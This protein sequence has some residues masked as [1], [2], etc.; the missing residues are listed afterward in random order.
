[1]THKTLT[2][3]DQ[4]LHGADYNPEQW[5]SHPEILAE[6]IRLMKLAGCN[7][8]SVGIFSWASLEPEE[9]N[10]TFEW[11]DHV[12]ENLYAN[13]IS[14]ILAT[15]SGARPA[16]LAQKYPEVLRT[17]GEN[18]KMKYGGRHN[19]CWSSRIYREK[20][21]AINSEL[22]LRYKDHPAI[23]MWHVSNEYGGE[24]FCEGCQAGFKTFIKDKYQTLEKLNEQYWTQFWSHAYTDW[25]QIEPPSKIGET[26]VHGLSID[27]RR[28]VTHQT[29]DF[30]KNEIEPLRHHTPHIPITTNFMDFYE[31]LDYH[32]F[33]EFLDVAS[34]DIYPPYRNNSSDL[35]VTIQ[36]AFT[37]DL[38]RG[39]KRKPFVLME[40]TPSTQNW[41]DI[42]TLKRPG[43]H[44][45]ASLQAVAHGADTVQYFQWRKSRG[46]SE[47]FH[48]AVVDHV[49]HEDTRVFKEVSEVGDILK[50]IKPV[51]A[52]HTTSKIA[53]VFDWDNWWAIN[54]YQGYSN[55]SKN[56]KKTCFSHYKALYNLG[57]NVDVISTNTSLDGY[58]MV[59]APQ[60]YMTKEAFVKRL[61]T[62]VKKGGQFVSTTISGIVNENDLV[63]LGGFPGPLKSLLGIWV[64]ETDVLYEDQF[65]AF[66]YKGASYRCN[67]YFDMIH[68]ETAQ[69]ESYFKQDFYKDSP[70]IT[71]NKFGNGVAHYIGSQTDDAFL[72]AFYEQ[73]TA[74]IKKTHP[75]KQHD[76]GVDITIRGDKFIFVLNSEAAEREVVFRANSLYMDLITGKIVSE[77]VRLAPFETL[78]LT[79]SE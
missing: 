55:I 38:I 48:G 70:V 56:Y 13:G 36:A 78:I 1:M 52:S 46:S 73:N 47:K 66:D 21:H 58:D 8:M 10:Y 3:I 45:F 60:L 65:N 53:I 16:W 35:D 31:G 62:F 18:Q 7:V 6:D 9:G 59:V 27:W 11:L 14:V 2:K 17:N 4:F 75:V 29:I 57:L 43:Q 34:I 30:Y 20:V 39:M 69:A 67:Q 49:G 22:A 40:S 74:L 51:L 71:K 61:E 76:I 23:V 26:E 12:I 68:L 41:Q 72:K 25:S 37:F 64:E 24:C 42:A 19:H 15:P 79:E 33:S 28:Y 32:L 77:Q 50:K 5:K 63:H 54:H 44:R